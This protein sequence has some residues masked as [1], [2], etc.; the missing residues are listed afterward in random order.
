M[1]GTPNAERLM[2]LMKML[3]VIDN[4]NHN[5]AYNLCMGMKIV[6]ATE[7]EELKVLVPQFNE[8][9]FKRS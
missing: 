4:E 6:Y 2:R 8:A 7:A 5:K 3:F 9:G 1:Q